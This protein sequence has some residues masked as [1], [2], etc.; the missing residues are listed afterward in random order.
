[1]TAPV[2]I[3]LYVSCRRRR[4]WWSEES[5][6]I[7]DGRSSWKRRLA[8][9]R[10]A[11]CYTGTHLHNRLDCDGRTDDAGRP[12]GR[13]D[14]T[15]YVVGSAA[16]TINSR[17]LGC[18]SSGSI[19]CR[20]NCYSPSRRPMPDWLRPRKVVNTVQQRCLVRIYLFVC[21]VNLTVFSWMLT[22]ACCLF[23][24]QSYTKYRSDKKNSEK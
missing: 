14:S 24:M 10:R 8:W 15:Q 4:R 19:C 9:R 23:I 1:M 17:L 2:F 12:G 7:A 16:A 6:A 22:T 21:V 11:R 20:S 18:T 5:Q 3:A 13:R